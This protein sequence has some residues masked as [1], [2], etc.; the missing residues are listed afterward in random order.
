[1]NCYESRTTCIFWHFGSAQSSFRLNIS[2]WFYSSG[3]I[4]AST[5]VC[6]IW[7]AQLYTEQLYI[8]FGWLNFSILL[9]TF[10][11]FLHFYWVLNC[12]TWAI[13]T[14]SFSIY[15]STMVIAIMQWRNANWVN[16]NSWNFVSLC[17]CILKFAQY[18]HYNVESFLF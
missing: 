6:N 11:T 16:C 4:R 1:M 9:F 15:S 2:S 7:L 14:W 10:L 13:I 3:A 5:A 18:F 8:I 17:K 12:W